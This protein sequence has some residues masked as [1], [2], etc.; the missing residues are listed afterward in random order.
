VPQLN[1]GLELGQ[2][3]G[4]LLTF[5]CAVAAT[6]WAG[7]GGASGNNGGDPVSVHDSNDGGWG[8]DAAAV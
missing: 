5:I 4:V 3:H 7:T 2:D 1:T 6:G 8:D